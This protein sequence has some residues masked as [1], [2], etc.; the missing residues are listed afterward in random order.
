MEELGSGNSTPG[1]SPHCDGPFPTQSAS[2]PGTL[3]CPCPQHCPGDLQSQERSIPQE[4]RWRGQDDIIRGWSQGWPFP[5]SSRTP[6]GLCIC[7]STC[8]RQLA[9]TGRRNWTGKQS[10]PLARQLGKSQRR[11]LRGTLHSGSQCSEPGGKFPRGKQCVP[12]CR[13]L[14]RALF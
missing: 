7:I 3:I 2:S 1:V 13:T 8:R 12:H 4:S 10:L 9:I 5:A 6:A 14:G 11:R